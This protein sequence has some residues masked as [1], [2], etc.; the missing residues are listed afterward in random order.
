MK[1]ALN[2]KANGKKQ[3]CIVAS[4]LRW[5]AGI[6]N[7]HFSKENNKLTLVSYKNY[8]YIFSKNI[9]SRIRLVRMKMG[10]SNHTET[11]SRKE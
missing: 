1:P 5:V 4:L 11:R 2:N 7:L 9:F 8:F 3:A 10:R 6:Y